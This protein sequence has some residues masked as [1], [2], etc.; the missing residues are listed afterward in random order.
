MGLLREG[1]LVQIDTPERVYR[2]PASPFVADFLGE[3]RGLKRLA[4]LQ[5]R[6]I[7]PGTGPP[8]RAS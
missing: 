4:L 8:L 1:R 6:Y 7:T 5:V 2:D 3:E